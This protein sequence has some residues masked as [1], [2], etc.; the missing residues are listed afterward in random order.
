MSG[1]GRLICFWRKWNQQISDGISRKRA[2]DLG[3]LFGPNIRDI[4]PISEVRA[5][6]WNPKGGTQDLRSESLVV[7]G[8]RD[9]GL[10]SGT[11]TQKSFDRWKPRP[12]TI[13]SLNLPKTI[14]VLLISCMLFSRRKI[15]FPVFRIS[16]WKIFHEGRVSC[17]FL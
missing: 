12:R 6:T 16:K 14:I 5:G 1:W 15:Y 7:C 9:S 10:W 8:T 17:F 11:Q 3:L 4:G 2:W 13:I